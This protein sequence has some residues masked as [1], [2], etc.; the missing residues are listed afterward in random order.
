MTP[1]ST[2]ALDRALTELKATLDDPDR[3]CSLTYE[4]AR[5]VVAELRELR[6]ELVRVEAMVERV[7]ALHRLLDDDPGHPAYCAVCDEYRWPCQTVRALD[8][9]S[10]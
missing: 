7:R 3:M 4:D 9:E 1:D 6:A 10:G 2:S 5:A 8:G